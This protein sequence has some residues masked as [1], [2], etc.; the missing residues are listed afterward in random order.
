MLAASAIEPFSDATLSDKMEKDFD[1]IDLFI[2]L[3][4]V[5]STIATCCVAS[6]TSTIVR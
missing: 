1:M 3:A 5:V 4:V 2:L 6:N